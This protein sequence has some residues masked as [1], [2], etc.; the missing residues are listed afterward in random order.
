MDSLHRTTPTRLS[1]PGHTGV[2]L[3]S[4]TGG[5]DDVRHCSTDRNG[6]MLAL[7]LTIEHATKPAE[8]VGAISRKVAT[9]LA[10]MLLNQGI[11]VAIG[12]T[13]GKFTDD[14]SLFR[15][16]IDT[17]EVEEVMSSSRQYLPLDEIMNYNT[18]R[19]FI[20]SI[21][22]QRTDDYVARAFGKVVSP[23]LT[24]S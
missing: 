21:L 7:V 4:T 1:N 17:V 11:I 23:I 18:T 12:S 20:T 15:F 9:E 13:G 3:V 19:A 5:H 10:Q 22:K 2:P 6:D 16:A 14:N 24:N 8:A